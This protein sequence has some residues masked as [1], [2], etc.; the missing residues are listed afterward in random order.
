MLALFRNHLCR[1]VAATV[2]ENEPR[3]DFAWDEGALAVTRLSSQAL[4]SRA[5][6]R[7]VGDHSPRRGHNG[8]HS[9]TRL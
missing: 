9:A 3:I 2:S 1:V 4:E 6:R 5:D 7:D 8:R